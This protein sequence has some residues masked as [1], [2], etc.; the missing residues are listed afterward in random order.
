VPEVIAKYYSRVLG[1]DK[2]N[3][4]GL[5]ERLVEEISKF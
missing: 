4:D 3:L 5:K 2:G 1:G